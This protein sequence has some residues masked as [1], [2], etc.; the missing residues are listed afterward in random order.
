MKKWMKRLTAI[1]L[2][3]MMCMQLSAC[4]NKAGGNSGPEYVYVAEY[5]DLTKEGAGSNWVSNLVYA[6]NK[7]YY[8]QNSYD[9]QTQVSTDKFYCLEIGQDAP[10]ELPITL[11]E[12][13]YVNRMYA[14]NSGNLYFVISSYDPEA[15]NPVQKYEIMKTDSVG[16]ETLR[17]DL[18]PLMDPD[19]PYIQYLCADGE[20]NIYL[21]AGDTNIY[22][23][24]G[25]SGSTLF[26]VKCD[27]WINGM[28]C[29]KEGKVLVA[30][31]AQSMVFKEIDVAA[32]G[33]G[34]TYENVPSGNGNGGYSAGVDSGLLIS[35][36]NTLYEYSTQTKESKE[37][38][39][40][41]DSDLNGD[42]IQ[43][44]AALDDGRILVVNTD[45]SQDNSR[46]ELIYLT[47]KQKSEVAEK[48]ELTLGT[49]YLNQDVKT[50][51]IK[52]NKTN[53]KYRITVKE[54]LGDNADYEKYDEIVAQMNADIVSGNGPDIIDISGG[55]MKQYAA[56]GILEDLY[57]YI[58]G[59]EE[60]KREDFVENVFKAYEIGGKLIA[61]VP[62]FSI[63]TV[64]GKVSDVGDRM[65]WTLDDLMKLMDEKPEGTEIFSYATKDSILMYSCMY[66]LDKY[67][68]W[69]TGQCS[70]NTPDFI[71]VL[72]FANKFS[73]EYNYDET[74]PSVPSK[75]QSG[76]LLLMD[77][78]INEVTDYQMYA[79]MFGE[80]TTFIGYPGADG[81]GS[82]FTSG[83]VSLGIN[84]KSKNKDAV[85]Q[86]L[87]TFLTD[88][89]Q[90]SDN[91][92]RWSFPVLKTELDKKFED[93]MTK[94][95]YTD[96]NGNQVEQQKT[97]WMY[98]DFSMDI[99]A[100]TQEDV[101]A[102]KE[103]INAT[104]NALQLDQNIQ[105]IITEE[106]GGYFQGQKTAQ[107][108]ADIIQSRIQ[109]YV[110]ENR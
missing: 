33:F 31:Y 18:S 3:V 95:Y 8:Q 25:K 46:T 48:T 2:A 59:D 56:K 1:G 83:G 87:R 24:D 40:W 6:N 32:K 101:D 65:G 49:M 29:S 55:N 100:A 26:N 92:R 37:L 80:P 103:L 64:M 71:E 82:F 67:V 99:Y 27:E 68:D 66:G 7:L 63:N 10:Q 105:N 43:L 70:F 4:S 81:N 94:E 109:I 20:G 98:D 54:Y 73:S 89:Y 62:Y 23:L 9:E 13:N 58:D 60:L 12:N 74:A 78:G 42:N 79:G 39:N 19:N 96:E 15:E 107:E 91:A 36:G 77:T 5:Q 61:V 22:V 34:T 50:E 28:G 75:I 108:V 110:N 97:S 72:E 52:F 76:K 44:A 93:A 45:Y 35:T 90:S 104:D 47:K 30:T 17:Q 11:P 38:L 41:I 86:F 16:N 51:I 21:S 88:D 85:W 14:D 57:P 53:D 106:A 69:S 84:S 102:I